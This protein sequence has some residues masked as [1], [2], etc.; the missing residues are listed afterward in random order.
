MIKE[1]QIPFEKNKNIVGDL[2]V[3][4]NSTSLLILCHGFTDNKDVYGIKRLAELLEKSINVFRFTFTD[5]EP[6]LTVE[7][8]NLLKVSKYFSEQYKTIVVA[9]HSLGG[10]S[11]LLSTFNNSRI[12]KLVLINPFVYYFKKVVWRFRKILLI[13]SILFPFS[14]RMR[15]NLTF[16]FKTLKPGQIK[17]PT[18]IIVG[19]KDQIV[20]PIHGKTLY[21]E[22]GAAQKKLIID[23]EIDHG[24][25]NEHYLQV[26]ADF[27]ISWLET[28]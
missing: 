17:L 14:H 10:L 3:Q 1:I 12:N 19:E 2:H 5:K 21:K 15:T 6:D 20:S 8:K 26:V 9:G 4:K 7:S 13:G 25:T 28:K 18:L 27:I 22:I 24:L 23:D 11:A 16:Y